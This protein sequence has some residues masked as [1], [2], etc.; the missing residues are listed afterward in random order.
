M[1]GS[2]VELLSDMNNRNKCIF[3]TSAS[4]CI[5]DERSRVTTPTALLILQ[6]LPA[7]PRQVS[8]HVRVR[9]DTRARQITRRV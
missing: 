4:A 9:L 5:I 8:S 1:P 2:P 3:A 6:P 7:A